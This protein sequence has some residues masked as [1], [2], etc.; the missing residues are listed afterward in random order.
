[1][2]KQKEAWIAFAAGLSPLANSALT[3]D[4]ASPIAQVTATPDDEDVAAYNAVLEG[5][6]PLARAAL[7][8]TGNYVAPRPVSTDRARYCVVEAFDGDWPRLRVYRTPE[9]MAKRVQKLLGKDVSV[10]CY[11]GIPLKVSVGPDRFVELP[12]GYQAIDVPAFPGVA[13][14]IREIDTDTVWEERGYVGPSY[15]ATVQPTEAEEVP[16]TAG[17]TEDDED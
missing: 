2:S 10:Y 5:L 4:E 1:M 12:N 14:K 7:T 17:G 8:K 9:A 15:L 11:F 3:R 16:S 13:P 6:S